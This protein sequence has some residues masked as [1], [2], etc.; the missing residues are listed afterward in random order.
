MKECV[1]GNVSALSQNASEAG[2][3]AVKLLKQ[4]SKV[5]TGAYKKGFKADVATDETG[6][7][8]TVHNRVYQLTHLLENGHA[9]K[10][11]TGKSYGT[12]PGDGVI[13]EVADQVAREFAEMGG[14]GQ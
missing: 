8:C 10:N 9:I 4:K 1:D 3:R 6:T 13:A 14:D 5:R 2:K 11:Q 12:V 7:E